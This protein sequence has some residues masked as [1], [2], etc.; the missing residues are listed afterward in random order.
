MCLT[1]PGKIV[2]IEGEYATV[3]YG[4]SGTRENINIALV[5]ATVG[6]YVLVQSGLAIRVLTE[7]E[8]QEALKA[9]QMILAELQGPMQ[10]A[11]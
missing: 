2:A 10:G 7:E 9:W 6:S 8:A 5:D 11:S 4:E 3:D 1:F